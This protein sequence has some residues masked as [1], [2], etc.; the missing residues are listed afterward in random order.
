[1]P[2]CCGAGKGFFRNRYRGVGSLQPRNGWCLRGSVG[3]TEN[4]ESMIY[5]T[6]REIV[7]VCVMAPE[8]PVTVMT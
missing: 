5:C 8:V 7:P 6:E 1:V 4:S 2:A 3:D